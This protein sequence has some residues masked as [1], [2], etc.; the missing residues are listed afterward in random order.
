M[1]CVAV[2]QDYPLP[3]P[4]SLPQSSVFYIITKNNETPEFFSVVSADF[5][6]LFFMNSGKP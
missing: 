6:L 1:K 5:Q 4:L 2:V 3:P